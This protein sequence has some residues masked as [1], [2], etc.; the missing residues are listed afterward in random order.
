MKVITITEW[1]NLPTWFVSCLDITGPAIS[2]NNKPVILLSV[3]QLSNRYW[4]INTV[5]PFYNDHTKFVGIVDRWSLVVQGKLYAIKLE[6]EHKMMIVTSR[7]STFW[8]VLSSGLTVN[9]KTTQLSWDF[10]KSIS[11]SWFISDLMTSHLML[12]IWWRHNF[13][14]GTH[15]RVCER[16]SP[17][18]DGCEMMCCG[19]GYNTIK[20]K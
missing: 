9:V 16:D 20:T 17:G 12:P 8:V 7:W 2:N 10:Q 11:W 19:R 5:K 13:F 18:M 6:I 15:G 4:C 3:I 1:F 14:A